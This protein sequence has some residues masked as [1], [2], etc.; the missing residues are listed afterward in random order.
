MISL[1]EPES[2]S[3]EKE[4]QIHSCVCREKRPATHR[5]Q[6]GPDPAWQ[7]GVTGHQYR[8]GAWVRAIQAAPRP[9]RADRPAEGRGQAG[10]P[11]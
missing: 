2:R 4:L 5:N 6:P 1:E 3:S 8:P 10:G 9:L 7:E 11:A